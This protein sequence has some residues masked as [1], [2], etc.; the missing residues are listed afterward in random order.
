MSVRSTKSVIT[1]P[2]NVFVM[3]DIMC[4]GYVAGGNTKWLGWNASGPPTSAMDSEEVKKAILNRLS[5]GDDMDG[6]Y[7]S[8]LAFAAPYSEVQSGG[9]EQVI[10]I[11]ERVLPWEVR[12]GTTEKR[13]F[14]GGQKGF[15]LYKDKY[16][17]DS[18]HYS[19]DRAAA[20]GMEFLSNVSTRSHHPF[21]FPHTHPDDNSFPHSSA[22]CV[23][24][25]QGAL[26]NATCEWPLST[27]PSTI[28][29]LNACLFVCVCVVTGI[30]GPHR[31]YNPVRDPCFPHRKNTH[32]L[33][34]CLA[35]RSPYLCVHVCVCLCIPLQFCS[36]RRTTTS[37]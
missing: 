26:N 35:S 12:A 8:M 16:G 4:T 2:Q 37:L 5:M 28:A 14:P 31:K 10:S 6:D 34:A 21:H 11:T 1:K 30:I 25:S 20:E 32:T 33:V 13:G 9:R 22:F 19:E 17:L 29:I 24:C 23:V 27:F 36:S 3:R 18:I 7:G 15:D